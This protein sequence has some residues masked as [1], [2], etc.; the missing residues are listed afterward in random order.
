MKDKCQDYQMLATSTCW[1][2]DEVEPEQ[3]GVLAGEVRRMVGGEEG[4]LRG[5]MGVM[6][7]NL[8]EGFFDWS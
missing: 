3:W 2:W 7:G 1:S 5:W 4:E 6:G 8:V